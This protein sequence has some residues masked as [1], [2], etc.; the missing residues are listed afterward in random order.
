MAKIKVL[1]KHVR[2]KIVTMLQ[3]KRWYVYWNLQGLGCKTGLSDLVAVK[4]GIVIWIEV[5]KPGGKQSPGQITFEAD[6]TGA[7]GNY[8]CA[9]SW[10]AVD[11]Y[12][13]GLKK[14]GFD[15]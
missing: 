15:L 3:I 14:Q 12:I 8:V 1:E 10:D 5:K 6:I 4:N 7:G 2:K 11:N 9:A 13:E